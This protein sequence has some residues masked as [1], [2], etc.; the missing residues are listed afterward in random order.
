VTFV[1]QAFMPLARSR[2]AALRRP[3]LPIITV[4][5]PMAILTPEQV[6]RL[7][8]ELVDQVLERLLQGGGGT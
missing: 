4:P 5:H 7:A 2:I 6:N 3:E 8:A 1:S